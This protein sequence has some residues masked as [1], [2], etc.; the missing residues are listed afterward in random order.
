MCGRFALTSSPEELAKR[1]GLDEVPSAAPRYNVAPGQDVLAIRADAGGRR[2]AAPL[3]WG[4]VPGWAESPAFGARTINARAETAATRPA[5]RAAFAERRC[6]VPADGF[7]EW[8]PRGD[9]RQPFWIAPTD[10]APL[11]FAALWERWQAPDGAPLE[12]CALLTTAANAAIAEL[13]PRMPV[14]LAPDAYAPWLAPDARDVDALSA[15]LGPLPDDALAFHPVGTRVNR[16][17]VDEPG[18]LEPVPD[19]PRQPSLFG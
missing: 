9:F 8:A 12:T 11:G 4:L 13:H 15:L 14:V 17:D 6:I 10:G 5:F 2:R 16:V 18:L 3:R 19:A 1:F 7:Y